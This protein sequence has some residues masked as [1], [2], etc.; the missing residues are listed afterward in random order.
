MR[1][2]DGD[3][4]KFVR[5]NHETLIRILKHSDDKFVRG[6]AL[7]ALIKYGPEPCLDDLEHDLTRARDE[8]GGVA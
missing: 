7:S 8:D 1:G 2:Y 3:P 6:L 5:E 4:E